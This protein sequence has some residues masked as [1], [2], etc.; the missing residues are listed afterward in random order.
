MIL[1][2]IDDLGYTHNKKFKVE[3]EK[4]KAFCNEMIDRL[5]GQ[6]NNFIY[7]TYLDYVKELKCKDLD[8][9]DKT[10][11][12]NSKEEYV[13]RLKFEMQEFKDLVNG[14]YTDETHLISI[15]DFVS[16]L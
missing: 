10:E 9:M 11:F 2:R 12:F 4:F 6:V 3:E 5:T 7:T 1:C 16:A 15:I 14:K 8:Y 13:K